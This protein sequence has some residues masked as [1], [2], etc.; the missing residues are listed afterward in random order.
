MLTLL[1][2]EGI[3]HSKSLDLANWLPGATALVV[4]LIAFTILALKVWPA[5][6]KGLDDRDQKIRDEIA[7]AEEAQ[8]QAKAA[9]A[10]YEENLAS[11]REEANQMIAKARTDAKAVAEDLRSRIE[12]DLAEMKARA[13]R[14]IEA[15]KHNAIIELHAEAATLASAVAS[16]I[17]EREISAG[18]QQRLVEA[19]LQELNRIQ[20]G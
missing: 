13:G 5:I 19:S 7:G 6:S 18:D 20:A 15:A 12:A 4:F 3:E 11:A 16:K 10:E 1:A 8:R 9:L 17:L 2:A 14:D